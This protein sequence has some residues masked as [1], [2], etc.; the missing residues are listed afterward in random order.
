MKLVNL[1]Y[2]LKAVL[3][4]A[5]ASSGTCSGPVYKTN[6]EIAASTGETAVDGLTTQTVYGFLDFTTTIANTVMVFSPQSQKVAE[7]NPTPVVKIPQTT[8]PPVVSTKVEVKTT[9]NSQAV[10]KPKAK[11]QPPKVKVEVSKRTDEKVAKNQQP[12]SLSVNVVKSVGTGEVKTDL[13]K[14]VTVSSNKNQES[15]K[16][17]ANS[18]FANRLDQSDDLTKS[19]SEKL[20]ETYK[21]IE[22]GSSV[23]SRNEP[24][25]LVTKLGGTVVKDGL[26]TV[27]KTSVI[28]TYISGKYAQVLKSNSRVVHNQLPSIHKSISPVIK[29]KHHIEPTVLEDSLPLEALFTTASGQTLVRHT[30]R[31]A[32][33]PPFKNRLQRTKSQQQEQPP[34]TEQPSRL[35]KKKSKPAFK[36]SHN[37]FTRTSASEVP[38]VSVFPETIATTRR[39]HR[40]RSAS[41]TVNSN[42]IETGSRRYK[43]RPSSVIAEASTSL[44]KFKLARPQGRWHYKTTPK[45]RVAIRRQDEENPTIQSTPTLPELEQSEQQVE[46]SESQI[47]PSATPT[48]SLPI[49]T[50]K[51]EI[52]TPSNFSNVYYEIATIKSPYT[53][54]VGTV[55]NTRY[56][57][58]TST[59]EKLLVQPSS[60]SSEPLTENI[61]MKTPVYDKEAPVVTLPPINIA[62]GEIV[63]LETM[64]DTF[65]TS[66]I[67][68]KT[69]LLPVVRDSN[70]TTI[71]LV[72]TYEV[73]KVVSA[74]KTLPPTELFQFIPSKTLNEFNTRLDEA[75]SELH[76]ELDFG[77]NDN[78]EEQHSIAVLP[79]F[80]NATI[81]EVTS[82]TP[83]PTQPPQEQLTPEKLQQLAFLRLLNPNQPPIVTSTPVLS[84]QTVFETHV[85]PVFNGLSTVFSTISRPVKTVT[86]TQYMTST[87]QLPSLPLP[88]LPTQPLL[89]PMITSSPVVTQTIITQTNSKVLRLTFGAKTA[90]TTLYSTTVLP[91]LLTTYLTTQVPIQPTVGPYPSPFFPPFNPFSF[92]G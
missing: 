18:L 37:R 75:G 46:L 49:H 9:P 14:K 17:D 70:T 56:I 86:N 62:A 83:Q 28:G 84:V 12:K 20:S 54:Q 63:P 53:F 66:E 82:T 71:T 5:M 81:E 72:Q 48:P 45:P 41:S 89:Q 74:T 13:K 27:H 7:I 80:P 77:D 52:S 44:Y 29:T 1:R 33:S 92:V 22:V 21:I 11:P 15:K 31:P 76:L 87:V 51:V 39:Y 78:D 35:D 57:T 47:S 73:T 6:A 4:L 64:T 55:K 42:N 8:P 61:L 26:T 40:Q 88:F 90:Y 43:P 85:I 16:E 2:L 79:D 25:G 30:R 36:L 68:L 10:E 91:T 59:F 24:T 60:S 65:S 69:H 3:L 67:L 50:I 38:T 34:S 58:L 19:P 32:V 23:K